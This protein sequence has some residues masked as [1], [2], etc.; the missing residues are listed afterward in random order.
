MFQPD[1]IRALADKLLTQQQRLAPRQQLSAEDRALLWRRLIAE[2][3]WT[4]IAQELDV[5]E[6]TARHRLN[7]ALEKARVLL[8]GM[9]LEEGREK[10]TKGERKAAQTEVDD[11]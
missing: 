1:G 5:S 6:S 2:Q 8:A 10:P 11:R 3:P 9:G 4:Q 7:R